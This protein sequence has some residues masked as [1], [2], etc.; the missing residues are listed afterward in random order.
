VIQR[1]LLKF[2]VKSSEDKA[3]TFDEILEE[4]PVVL[5][6]LESRLTSSDP[7]I[8]FVGLSIEDWRL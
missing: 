3:P 5:G 1:F 4:V 8:V 6:K 2:D 7:E